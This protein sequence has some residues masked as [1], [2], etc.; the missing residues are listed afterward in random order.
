MEKTLLI[1]NGLNLAMGGITWSDLLSSICPPDLRIQTADERDQVPQPIQFEMIGVKE[2]SCPY[3]R[4]IDSY[5]SLKKKIRERLEEQPYRFG[6][7]H[8]SVYRTNADNIIT[9]NYDYALE[10]ASKE[11]N[12]SDARQWSSN[13]K[14]LFT[15]TGRTADIDFFHCHGVSNIASSICVG[16]EHYMGYV[17]HMRSLL[18]NHGNDN[19][20]SDKPRIAYIL[21]GKVEEPKKKWPLL[22]FESDVAIIGLGLTFSEIDLWW[23]LTLRAAF[24]TGNPESK[25][26]MNNIVYY[27]VA[28][29]VNPGDRNLQE[30]EMMGSSKALALSGL[31]V[32]YRPVIESSY[33]AGYAKVLQSLQ[34]GEGWK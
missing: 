13:Q 23:L 16:Y 3:R 6:W 9:T 24:F 33:T 31:E 27:D 5:S 26:R 15:A 28:E 20:D 22:F 29:L 8:E 18:V 7:L 2:N 21:D 25:I 17:H 4:G 12:P 34:T 10:E 19:I 14:Y 32:Q 11:W 30:K 1:G